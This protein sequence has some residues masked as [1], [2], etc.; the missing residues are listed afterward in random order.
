MSGLVDRHELR[1]Q[2]EIGQRGIEKSVPEGSATRKLVMLFFD[3]VYR[4]LNGMPDIKT[5]AA[6]QQ[7]NH[8]GHMTKHDDP[9]SHWIRVHR[10]DCPVCDVRPVVKL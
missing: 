7:L 4:I 3:T 5:T 8:T 2:L 10:D 6:A 9:E 1:K